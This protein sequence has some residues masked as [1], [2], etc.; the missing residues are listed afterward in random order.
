VAKKSCVTERQRSQTGLMVECFSRLDERLGVEARQL[1][2][3]AQELRGAFHADG[4]LQVGL[5]QHLAQAAAELAI[6]ADVDVRI[7]EVAH[8]GQVAAQRHHHVDLGADAFDQAADLGQ[9]RGHVERAVH[10]PEDVDAGL[11]PSSRFFSGGI[12]PLVMPN[13]VKIQVIARSALSH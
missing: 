8:L 7:H 9:V 2:Q 11:A 12:R 4:R 6:H 10:R 5:A 13:S 1:A 3:L